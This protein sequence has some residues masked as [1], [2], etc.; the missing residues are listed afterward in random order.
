MTPASG[1]QQPTEPSTVG[2]ALAL[3]VASPP[4]SRIRLQSPIQAA[5]R[6]KSS[7]RLESS[8]LYCIV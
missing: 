2:V 6:I 5:H 4:R 1:G 7:K 8:H 3:T